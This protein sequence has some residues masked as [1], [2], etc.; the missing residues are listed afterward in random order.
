VLDNFRAHVSADI[1]RWAAEHNVELAFVPF[2][3]SWLNRIEAQFQA[4]RYF[5]I[6]GIDH[7]S[8]EAQARMIRRYIAWRNRNAHDNGLRE[9]VKRANVA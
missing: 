5:T 6:D 1:R 3:A 9:I 8:H 4:L 2:Y 7:E